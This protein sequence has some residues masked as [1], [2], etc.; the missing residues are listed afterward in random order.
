MQS[1]TTGINTIRMYNP[2][3]QGLEHDPGGLFIR[4]WVHELAAVPAVF[5]HQPWTM[6]AATQERAGCRIGAQ[7]PSPIV[8]WAAAAATARDR[9]WAL[10]AQQGFAATADAIQLR[11]G[12]RRSGLRTSS[13]RRR[14]K[15]PIAQLSLDLMGDTCLGE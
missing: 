14:G 12:S 1:G 9:L 11:H 15:A 10:R 7:Y 4:H 13:S 8:N 5:L 6:D 3:K 2:F